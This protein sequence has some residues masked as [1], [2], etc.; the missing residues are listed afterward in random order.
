M[1]LSIVFLK[2]PPS[3]LYSYQTLHGIV[4][5]HAVPHGILRPSLDRK[6]VADIGM[7]VQEER[8]SLRIGD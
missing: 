6:V 5:A 7:G 8:W 1:S 3:V 4:A 2:Q